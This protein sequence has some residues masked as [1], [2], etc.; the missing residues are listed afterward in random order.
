[1][2]QIL[3]KRARARLFRD[4]LAQAMATGGHSQSGLARAAGVDRSTI[5]QLLADDGPRLPNAQVVGACAQVLGVSADWLL[6]LSDRPESAQALM[7]ASSGMTD[8]P[9]ALVDEQI[10]RWH[11]EAEG[12]K[13]R[14]VPATLPDLLKTRA[15]L[16]WEYT[17]HLGRTAE[18]AIN[19]AEDRLGWMRAA[20]SDF[21]IAMPVHELTC[22]ARGEGYYA[23]LPAS[24]R[25]AQLDHL[26]LLLDQLYPRL[27]LYLY[28]GHRLFAAP[29]TVFGPQLVAFYI[30]Q[31]YLTFRDAERVR[32]CIAQFDNLVREADVP[33]REVAGFARLLRDALAGQ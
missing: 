23:G 11:R 27:R 20:K 9:R 25:L 30:G 7:A 19:A 24:L 5:S 22:M 8:A 18:Q 16:E 6:G 3:D 32:A 33:A 4:R 28:D 15:I 10:F 1:M 14:Y 26:A 31:H 13:I 21:E 29:M 17:P 2:V 12:T